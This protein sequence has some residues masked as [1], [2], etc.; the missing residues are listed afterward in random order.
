[1]KTLSARLA[2]L[3]IRTRLMGGFSAVLALIV[4]LTAIGIHQVNRID[5]SLTTINDINGVKLRHAIDW[6][7]SVHDRA[8]L[9]RDMTLVSTP[10]D[11]QALLD[12]YR[13][14]ETDYAQA[15]RGMAEVLTANA[16]GV[17][18]T[19][20]QMLDAIDDQAQR[21]N[22][23][24][25][26]IIEQRQQGD[27]ESPRRLLLAE[28][29]PAFFQWLDDING[30]IDHQE[31]QNATTTADA[32]DT[33]EGF[34]MLMLGL[35]LAALLAG[36]AIAYLLS[37]QLLRELGA[38][39]R[40]VRAF[41]EAIGRGKLATDGRLRKN[42]ERSIMAAQVKMARQLQG[43]V[44]QVRAAAEAVAGN[45]EQIAEG[46]TDLASRTQQQASA[47]TQTASAMEQLNGTVVQ[48]TEN[49]GQ[50]SREAENASHTARQGGAAVEQMTATMN[51][52]DESAGEIASIIS[53]IDDI[54]FQT[55][56]LALNASVEAARAGEHGRGF[57]VVAAEV[58]K[59]AQKSA[60]AASEINGLITGNVERVKSGNARAVEARQAT[61]QII[62]AIARVSQL[63]HE[64]S[65]ASVEQSA[66]V[67]EAGTAVAEMDRV[68]QQNATLVGESA[69]A[70]GNLRQHARQLMTAMAAFQLPSHGQAAG[71]VEG[72]KNTDPQPT[73][74]PVTHRLP[75]ADSKPQPE[76]TSF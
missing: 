74:Q 69:T 67:Q 18:A 70:A 15:D 16:D 1:M 25:E 40:E 51:E 7:G 49:A 20:R 75:Q 37:R 30:F 64:I 73:T 57:A 12:A 2:H 11:L 26:R 62:E 5:H 55:N 38:E 29:G 44:T 4:L 13:Q 22:A 54:A 60:D 21:T 43:I 66:G 24:A 17:T 61:E 39:P 46:N 41:A 35:C 28:A 9:L 52:L 59:L 42:D 14:L 65:Q 58:R 32:R 3:G 48:N 47:L 31:T 27:L 71:Q 19:E 8:I 10:S 50:A 76:W 72:W 23:L 63:M 68:T 34:Q 6:R 53:T 33:A 45:S 56:I 36:G